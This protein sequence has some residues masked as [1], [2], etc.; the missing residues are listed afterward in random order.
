MVGEKVYL[1][2][3]APSHKDFIQLSDC[4]ELQ[5]MLFQSC[6][7]YCTWHTLMVASIK[8]QSAKAKDPPHAR[9][10]RGHWLL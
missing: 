6:L 5:V 9:P 4:L 2:E 8:L 10:V 3:A 1:G 7:A